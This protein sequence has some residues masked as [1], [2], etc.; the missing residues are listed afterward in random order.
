[1]PGIRPDEKRGVRRR[2]SGLYLVRFLGEGVRSVQVKD[3]V[4]PSRKNT[5]KRGVGRGGQFWAKKSKL[6][7][8]G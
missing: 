8:N 2:G 6:E 4:S 1:V 7:E 3:M 5:L